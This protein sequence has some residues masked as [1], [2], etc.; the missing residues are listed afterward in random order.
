MIQYLLAFVA[1][2]TMT[3]GVVALEINGFT[4]LSRLAAL[5]PVITWIGYLFI[6]DSI[7]GE[8]AVS[9]HALFVVLG[10]LVAWVP[11]MLILYYFSPKIGV[12]RAIA[13]GLVVFVILALLFT[14]VYKD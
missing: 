13:F 12:H 8:Q 2:G 10:T 7:G 1:G 6:G 3:L 9:K 11:Y 14:A 4:L 5:F